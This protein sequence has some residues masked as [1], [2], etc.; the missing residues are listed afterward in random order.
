MMSREVNGGLRIADREGIK[1]VNSG[2][3]IA[4]GDQ[5]WLVRSVTVQTVVTGFCTIR[6]PRSAVH[7]P[8][9]RAP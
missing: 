3:R 6:N 5:Q 7:A 8:A 2:F 1:A 9:Q 4:D